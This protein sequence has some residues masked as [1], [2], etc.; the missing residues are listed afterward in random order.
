MDGRK[1]NGGHK[2]AGRKPK[3]D[4]QALVEKLKP[5]ETL[6]HEALKTGL[7]KK[8]PWAIKLFFEYLYGKPKQSVNVESEGGLVV[9]DIKWLKRD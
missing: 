7:E 4:E 3:S 2:T 8:A 6:A 1:N 9:P 5:M